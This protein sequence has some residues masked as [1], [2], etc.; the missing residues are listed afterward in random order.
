MA[1]R[2]GKSA[3]VVVMVALV[4]L[5]VVSTATAMSVTHTYDKGTT[6]R[7]IWDTTQV[8]C[9]KLPHGV[10][11]TGYIYM[12]LKWKPAWADL[13]LYLLNADA[14]AVGGVAGEMGYLASF[15]GREVVCFNVD[16]IWNTDP[17]PYSGDVPGD[18]YYVLVVAFNDAARFQISGFYPQLAD[19]TESA[20]IS[21][22]WN[23]YLERFRKPASADRW[24]TIRGPRYGYPYDFRPTSVGKVEA[25]LEWPADIVT[26]VVNYTQDDYDNYV[27]PANFEQYMYFGVDWDTVWENYGDTNWRPPRQDGSAWFGLKNPSPKQTQGTSEGGLQPWT[28]WHY[29]PSLYMVAADPLQGPFGGPKL[30]RTTMGFK[31]TLIYPENLRIASAPRRVTPGKVAVMKG[32]FALNGDWAPAGIKVT[33][34]RRAAGG[35]WKNVKTTGATGA[36]GKWTVR[37]VPPATGF[38]RVMAPGDDATGLAT[39][40]SNMV[41]IA[42]R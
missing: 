1:K 4:A 34:Q 32:T 33:V 24:I 30:G 14:Q 25:H 18:D 7:V 40:L 6:T 22:P 26:K 31:A 37:F 39:E 17:D 16:E 38:Y 12:E 23:Y 11:H 29:V 27:M 10:N 36:D 5:V 21:D 9:Y 20:N 15:T 35:V 8:A 28:T 13:D 2:L 41:R 42:V 19:P 3:V